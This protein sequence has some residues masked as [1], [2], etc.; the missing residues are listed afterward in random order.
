[1]EPE[2]AGRVRELLRAGVDWELLLGQ[3]APWHRMLP[4]LAWHLTGAFAEET[5][6]P[7]LDRLQAL[8][9]SNS[10]RN[11]F[12]TRELLRLTALLQAEG[13]RAAPFKGPLLAMSVYGKL[14]LREFGDLDI[15]VSREQVA[16]ARD[17]LVAQG[18][19]IHH[20]SARALEAIYL[21]TE[22]H[23]MFLH[24]SRRNGVELHCEVAP[25]YF[26]FPLETGKIL[27]RLEP[28][29][30]AGTTVQT[31]S[32]QDLLLML[33]MHGTKHLWERVELIGCVA[34]LVRSQSGW[35]WDGL[36][37]EAQALGSRR[38]VLLALLLAR[39][40]CAAPLPGEI[41]SEIE[42]DPVL[43]ELAA[44]VRRRIHGD[45]DPVAKFMEKP[46]FHLRARERWADRL[47]YAL[48]LALAPNW[49]E[50]EFLPLPRFLFP[51]YWVLRPIRVTG[52]FGRM[53]LQQLLR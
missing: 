45:P 14:S 28:V 46:W 36:M 44:E 53:K 23:Y 35:D 1:M 51:L 12:L 32:R 50:I 41:D 17:L 48:R 29:S 31:L 19:R 37:R 3:I 42:A 34:E 20:P 11:L 25:W 40:L 15:L 8:F 21:R 18:Y 2:T 38:M 5:P 43:Q 10:V 30:V 39:S 49:D 6:R 47:R 13:V 9:E 27:E 4:L 33:C 26:S 7:V 52:K 24:E 16:K 22:Y